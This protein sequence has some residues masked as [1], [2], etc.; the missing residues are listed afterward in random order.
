M[1]QKEQITRKQ[2]KKIAKIYAAGIVYN[3]MGCGADSELFTEEQNEMLQNE[4][5]KWSG[6]IARGLPMEIFKLASLNQI[7]NYV[8]NENIQI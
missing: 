4:V 1:S 2:I 3:A 8:R 6:R 7:V 5:E